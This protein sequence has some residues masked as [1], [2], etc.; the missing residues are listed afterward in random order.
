[1]WVQA[2]RAL[3]SPFWAAQLFSGASS[4][5]DNPVLGSP[6]LN[7]LGLH[8]W[9]AQ[10]AHRLAAERRSRLAARVSAADRAAFERDGF[11]VKPD[12]LPP[13]AF[14]DLVA[15]VEA[16]RGPGRE[17]VQG[18]ALTRRIALEPS[19][20]ARLPAARDLLKNAAWRDLIDYVGSA[21]AEPVHYLQTVLT[22]V[23]Q[24]PPDPQMSLHSDTF[25]PTV[26]AWLFLTDVAE[27]AAPLT[28]VPGS[29]RLTPERL[30]WER[31][32]SVAAAN[33]TCPLTARG[34]FRINEAELPQLKLPPPRRLAVPANTLVVADTF[35]FHARG[36]STG[37]T[38]RVEIWAYG[39]RNPFAPLA[40]LDLWGFTGLASRRAPLYWWMRDELERMNVAPNV[41]KARAECSAF[42][43]ATP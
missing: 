29:H 11:V 12:F 38:R 32:V 8:A 6:R 34:A 36:P 26:K 14:A 2:R 7:E 24:T 17:T 4:F 22:R 42:D 39:R 20:L 13:D 5:V 41:W 23:E 30:A 25:H 40:G 10:L 33:S 43:P 28:Y 16:Y 3:M 37:P 1:M 15:Q 9:R 31:R 35:G 21:R 19:A 18:D 27:D